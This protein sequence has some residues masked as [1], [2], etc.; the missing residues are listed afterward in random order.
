[1]I[2]GLFKETKITWQALANKLTKLFDQYGL[3]KIIIAHV[4]DDG[5]ILY[6][7]ITALKSIVGCEVLGLDEIFQGICFG[8]VFFKGMFICYY[9]WK[10]L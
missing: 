4:K 2:I 7:M 5:S 10:C 8:H 9:W 3:K 6:I 1:M